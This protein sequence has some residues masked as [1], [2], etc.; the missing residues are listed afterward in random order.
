MFAFSVICLIVG[1]GTAGISDRYP[2]RGAALE[3]IAG[4]LI[5]AG[6]IPIGAGLPLFR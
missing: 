3:R 6:L 1:V 2:H 5:L 4:C